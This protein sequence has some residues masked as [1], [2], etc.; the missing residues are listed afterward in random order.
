MIVCYMLYVT[1][2]VISY[3]RNWCVPVLVCWRRHVDRWVPGS[4]RE[5]R[6]MRWRRGTWVCRRHADSPSCW[7]RW[8]PITHRSASVVQWRFRQPRRAR[9][10]HC[11]WWS[12]GRNHLFHSITA[13]VNV[14][15]S[16]RIPAQH[17]WSSK[18]KSRLQL[19]NRK[20][21]NWKLLIRY[22]CNL[23]RICVMI[24][25]RTDVDGD[26]WP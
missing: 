7:R 16:L 18:N 21:T 5:T 4:H 19:Q 23:L 9:R 25:P 8:L 17:A 22:W 11:V 24:N 20:Y 15:R 2:C 3:T 26:V 12:S 14:Y 10:T 1:G 13:L 6:G